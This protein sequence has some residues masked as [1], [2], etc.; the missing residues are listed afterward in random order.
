MISMTERERIQNMDH[1]SLLL[2]SQTVAGHAYIE[3]LGADYGRYRESRELLDVISY[4]IL[5]RM[6]Y[7]PPPPGVKRL[8]EQIERER[9]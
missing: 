4:E 9:R 1:Q 8:S 6:K 2:Y 5:Q 7:L 3:Q